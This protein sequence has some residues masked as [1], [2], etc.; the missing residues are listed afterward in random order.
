MS[1][2][3]RPKQGFAKSNLAL[4][5]KSCQALCSII[6]NIIGTINTTQIEAYVAKNILRK[7]A[8]EFHSIR[9]NRNSKKNKQGPAATLGLTLLER[10]F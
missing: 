7:S 8:N 9:Y 6:K 4:H 2:D 1:S 3:I 10:R 5:A